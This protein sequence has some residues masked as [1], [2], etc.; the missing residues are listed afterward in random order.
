[1][2][3]EQYDGIKLNREVEELA[4]H[5]I[6]SGCEGII[7]KL[8]EEKSLV[9]FYNPDDLGD[10]AYAMVGNN[11]LIFYR[12]L[13]EPIKAEMAQH[14]SSINPSKKPSFEPTRLRE[15]DTVRV[16]VEKAKYAKEGVHEGMIGTI[17]EPEKI[18]GG[19][20]VYFPDETGADT[21]LCRI[22]ETDL[23]LI[24]HSDGTTN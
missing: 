1:M 8:G 23:E 11:D 9:L 7:A 15:Y 10:Y 5:G 24:H 3:L 20:M 18:H 21:I 6:H 2:K 16:A 13:Q 12:K 4:T 19:W 22:Q 14:L 17:L